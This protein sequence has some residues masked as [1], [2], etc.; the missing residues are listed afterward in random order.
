V[1][2]VVV[3][4]FIIITTTTTTTMT[5]LPTLPFPD[6]D[7]AK[8]PV[9]KPHPRDRRPNLKAL[10]DALIALRPKPPTP[11]PGECCQEVLIMH[12]K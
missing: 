11:P 6:E 1:V 2:L 7:T 5:T 8:Q 3:I 12:T 10:V 9:P 4:V